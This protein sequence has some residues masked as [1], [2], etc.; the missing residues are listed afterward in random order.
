MILFWN[1]SQFRIPKENI[2]LVL[3]FFKY[4]LFYTIVSPELVLM[5]RSRLLPLPG[6]KPTQ[7]IHL[8]S[9]L[10]S[11]FFELVDVMQ[12]IGYVRFAN[13]TIF[14]NIFSLIDL[15][16]WFISATLS[17]INVRHNKRWNSKQT[18]NLGRL[19]NKDSR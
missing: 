8:I 13:T 7:E 9:L 6:I 4:L 10:M 14:Q 3:H 11:Q 16:R 2:N 19:P 1:L 5:V 12:E 15:F 17:C 18:Q